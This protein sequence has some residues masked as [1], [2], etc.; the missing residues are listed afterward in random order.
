MKI[1]RAVDAFYVRRSAGSYR[2]IQNRLRTSVTAMKS[3]AAAEKCKGQL[4]RNVWLLDFRLLQHC[5][6]KAVVEMYELDF[7]GFYWLYLAKTSP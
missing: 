2:F 5:R 1:P 6:R 4:W 3:D 7:A